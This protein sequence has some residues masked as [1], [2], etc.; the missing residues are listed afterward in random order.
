MLFVLSFLRFQNFQT[1]IQNKK[2]S[3]HLNWCWLRS[4]IPQSDQKISDRKYFR[5]VLFANFE[6]NL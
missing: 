2:I 3:D 6:C 1:L 4:L 5:S